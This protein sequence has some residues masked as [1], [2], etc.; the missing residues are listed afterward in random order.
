MHWRAHLRCPVVRVGAAVPGP[1]SSQGGT[2][3]VGAGF[4]HV[5]PLHRSSPWDPRCWTSRGMADG[6]VARGVDVQPH[7]L[8][9]GQLW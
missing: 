5:F 9:L 3:A 2:G 1:W 6:C 7:L 8:V 4:W